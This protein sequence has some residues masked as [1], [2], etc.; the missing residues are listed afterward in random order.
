MT[1]ERSDY[2]CVLVSVLSLYES[3]PFWYD[4]SKEKIL[5]AKE[6]ILMIPVIYANIID[7][8]KHLVKFE[9]IYEAYYKQIFYAANRILNDAYEAEDAVQD[10]FIGIARNMKTVS[11]ITNKTDLF[12]YVQTAAKHAALNRLPKKKI[13]AESVPLD[14]A[15]VISDNSFWETLCNKLTCETLVEAIAAVPETYREVLYYHLVMGFSVKETASLLNI[16]VATAKQQLVR[17][18]KVL[19]QEAEKRGAFEHGAE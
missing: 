18:K 2:T 1:G 15:P 11:K 7:D 13:Y 10:A 8:P 12:Y 9:E 16:K 17:G 3:A 5:N 19:I 4:N 14:D 6:R